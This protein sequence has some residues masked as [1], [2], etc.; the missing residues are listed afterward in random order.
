MGLKNLLCGILEIE[1]DFFEKTDKPQ[2]DRT[3]LTEP[4]L[5]SVLDDDTGGCVYYNLIQ[6]KPVSR[7]YKSQIV[8]GI[9]QIKNY[10]P[11]LHQ[12]YQQH[13]PDVAWKPIA[14]VAKVSE[15]KSITKP[16]YHPLGR[17]IFGNL[18]M[19]NTTTQ[20]YNLLMPQWAH[21]V[22]YR[23]AAS[24]SEEALYQTFLY[25]LHSP[26]LIAEYVKKMR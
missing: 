2:N 23:C 17:H 11:L 13:C 7:Y 24:A 1:K 25:F 14:I 21:V 19:H 8:V 16:L 6:N 22:P 18:I 12:R 9:Q 20:N 5:R 15:A 26:E 3:P 4:M 10:T